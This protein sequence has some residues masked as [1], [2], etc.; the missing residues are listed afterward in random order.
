MCKFFIII[1]IFFFSFLYGNDSLTVV[2]EERIPYVKKVEN[3]VE[4]LVASP[5]IKALE[6]GKIDYKLKERPSKRHL[7]EIKA[8][9]IPMCAMGWFKNKER[10]KYAKYTHFVY[11]DNP[12]GIIARKNPLGIYPNMDID[13][14][15]L[16]KKN[17][18]LTKA[19]YSYGKL[20]DEKIDSFKVNKKEVYNDNQKMLELISK[21][22]ADYMFMTKEEAQIL[23]NKVNIPNL[24]F[25]PI[26]NIP[27]GNKR[28]LI[29][30]KKV[31]NKII[32]KINENIK[33][34]HDL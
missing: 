21:K 19:S 13:N 34:N 33:I 11:Q 5:I 30:S 32:E 10:E 24:Q 22:R 15:L 2:Y 9:T 27:K 29:C 8:N 14:L 4:G 6:K 3:S 28:Y 16:N 31:S 1:Y 23:L 7:Y 17:S 18:L 12:M 26:K 20:L 25:Y